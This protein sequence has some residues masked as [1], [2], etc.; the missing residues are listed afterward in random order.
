MSNETEAG[1]QAVDSSSDTNDWRIRQEPET[2]LQEIDPFAS[3]LGLRSVD[4]EIKQAIDPILRRVEELRAL[5]AGRTEL[6]SAGNSEAS[7]W[8]CDNAS[9][10]PPRIWHDTRGYHWGES[11]LFIKLFLVTA[12]EL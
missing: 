5:L 11:L 4:E 9:T 3:E 6:V 10:S 7:V 12:L 1:T 2:V 8:R